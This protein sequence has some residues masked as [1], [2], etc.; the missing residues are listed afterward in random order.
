MDVDAIARQR[1]TRGFIMLGVGISMVV[2]SVILGV[3]LFGTI[4]VGGILFFGGIILIIFGSVYICTAQQRARHI[5]V[6][7]TQQ[8][9]AGTVVV[10]SNTTQM[11]YGQS[12]V[13]AYSG[14]YPGTAA[15]GMNDPYPQP[16]PYAPAPA[17]AQQP[18]PYGVVTSGQYNYAA[19]ND[20]T[21]P[22]NGPPT[23]TS[24]PPGEG[25]P[26]KTPMP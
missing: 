11:N 4:Y 20:G 2:V 1:R 14:P 17:Y 7:Q 22:P 6:L 25:E 18:P 12:I 24:P 10:S 16:Q 3:V 13:P 23:T 8:S 15:P 19:P 5:T 21:Y 9:G 26:T